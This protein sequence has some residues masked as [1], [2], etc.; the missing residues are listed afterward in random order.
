MCSP[1]VSVPIPDK[2]NRKDWCW[3]I[4]AS[5]LNRTLKELELPMLRKANQEI[6]VAELLRTVLA[7]LIASGVMQPF[8]E[9]R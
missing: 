1:T 6:F 3:L 7:N 4:D 9:G 8:F 5:E 2:S